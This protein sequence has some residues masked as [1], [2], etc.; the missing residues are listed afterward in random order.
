MK[1]II[2]IV[3]VS[4]L[5]FTSTAQAV[6]TYGSDYYLKNLRYYGTGVKARDPLYL[7]ILS[8]II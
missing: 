4:L 8:R 2:G 1:R 3:V 6:L 7:K 5:L